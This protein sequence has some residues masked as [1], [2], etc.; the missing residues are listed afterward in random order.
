MA[1]K[2]CI[3]RACTQHGQANVKWDGCDKYDVVGDVILLVYFRC[4][5]LAPLDSSYRCRV[6]L[7]VLQKGSVNRVGSNQT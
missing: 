7:K 5:L 6:W 3:K 2:M 4:Q 1:S